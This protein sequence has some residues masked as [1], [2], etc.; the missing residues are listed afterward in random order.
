M[1]PQMRWGK[2]GVGSGR[3]R[4]RYMALENQ[5]VGVQER[6]NTTKTQNPGQVLKQPPKNPGQVLIQHP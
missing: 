1:L 6:V 4:N 5:R 2:R 3:Y